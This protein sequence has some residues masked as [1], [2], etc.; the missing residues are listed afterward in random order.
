MVIFDQKCLLPPY[1]PVIIFVA[2]IVRL[3]ATSVMNPPP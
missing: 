3:R 2:G 1:M